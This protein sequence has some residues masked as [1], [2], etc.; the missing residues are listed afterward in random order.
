MVG[1]IRWN[2]LLGLAGFVLILLSSID[3]NGWSLALLRSGYGFAAFFILAFALRVA[4]YMLVGPRSAPAVE[5]EPQAPSGEEDEEDG[6]GHHFDHVTP[7]DE[8]DLIALAQEPQKGEAQRPA[9]QTEDFR[10]L[11]PPKLVSTQDKSPEELAE[12]L[13]H[14]AAQNDRK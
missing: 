4:L 2:L 12:A 13:R 3:S 6:K 5:H 8:Q 7:D 10:K 1:S 14:L 11:S 9:A